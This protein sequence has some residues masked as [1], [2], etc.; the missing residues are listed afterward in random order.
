MVA[1]N[2]N[3][4]ILDAYNA[5]PSSM[6]VA[7]ANF[8]QLDATEKIIIL[9][10]MFE[11]GKESLKEHENI[12]DLLAQTDMDCHF[13]GKDFYAV[14]QQKSNYHFYENFEL[15]KSN[16]N[17]NTI[18]NKTILIKGSRGMALERIIEDK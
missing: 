12:L 2:S 1:K 11:L 15:L 14:K 7:I 16:I 5:N 9:G 8:L 13:V 17:F 4:I 6:A 3:Q 10:D 18:Q